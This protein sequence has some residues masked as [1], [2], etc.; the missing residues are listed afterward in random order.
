VPVA[1]GKSFQKDSGINCNSIRPCFPFSSVCQVKIGEA[2]FNK[3]FQ[4]LKLA[5]CGA[6]G[7][8]MNQ[9]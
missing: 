5:L 2:G 6:F 1:A 9:G 3:E 8:E 4:H 7:T